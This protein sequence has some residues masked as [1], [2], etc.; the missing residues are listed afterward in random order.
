[1]KHEFAFFNKG[2]VAFIFMKGR[3]SIDAALYSVRMQWRRN[4]R[5][6]K[7]LMHEAQLIDGDAARLSR[8]A[9]LDP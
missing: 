9:S 6:L 7:K 1:M 8:N 4:L 3:K 2:D 5:F